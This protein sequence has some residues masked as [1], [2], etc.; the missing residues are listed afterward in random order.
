MITL[1]DII[2]MN[3]CIT[4]LELY[5]RYPDGYLIRHSIIGQPYKLSLHQER[6]R[7]LGKLE[8]IDK[9]INI[10]GRKNKAGMSEMSFGMK[11]SEIPDRYLDAE[12]TS[13]A[14]LRE[15]LGN[16]VPGV[17]LHATI[18]PIQMTIDMEEA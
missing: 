5:V 12:V 17:E 16:D 1:R 10:H 3:E 18:V 2:K 13:I 6:D 4:L 7:E 11:W 15:R 8:Y 9:D 14:R